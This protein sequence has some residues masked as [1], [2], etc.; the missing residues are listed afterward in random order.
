MKTIRLIVLFVFAAAV[1]ASCG[2]GNQKKAEVI[3]RLEAG[4]IPEEAT[5]AVIDSQASQ[6]EWLGTKVTGSGHNGVI[7]IKEGEIIVFDGRLWGANVVIDMT[8]IGVTDLTD[9]DMN[10]RLKGHL[11]SDDFFGVAS[12]PEANFQFVKFEAIEGAAVGQPNYRVSG[13]L[14]LKGITH[15]LAFP[16]TINHAEGQVT[17]TADF[18]FD[19]SLF[20]VR[21]GSGRF[22]E[23]LGDNLINDNVNIK[24]NITAAY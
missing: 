12:F 8:S 10:S 5:R 1:L 24:L 21:F 4:E 9:P 7:S 11:E 19:R 13:N 22:F 2:A 14:T 23:N 16:A 20:D 18:D 3:A 15:S 6:V 17:A